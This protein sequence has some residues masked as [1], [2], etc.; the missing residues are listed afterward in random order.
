MVGLDRTVDLDDRRWSRGVSKQTVAPLH[1][2]WTPT[3]V[4][5]MNVQTGESAKAVSLSELGAITRGQNQ[6]IVGVG[7]N[8]VFLK[9]LRLP[10]AAPDDLRSVL[11]I[12]LGQLFPVPPDQLS[13]DFIQTSNQ[14]VEGYLT[15]VAAMRSELLRDLR[16]ELKEVG[17][18]PVRILPI[19]LASGLVAARA[20]KQ[21]ALV[22]EGGAHGLALDVVEGGVTRFSRQAS[23]GS[24]ASVE[25]KRTLSAAKAGDLPTVSVGTV[26]I[27]GSI[28]AAEGALALLHEAPHFDFELM[29]ERVQAAKRRIANRL[30]LASAFV[31]IALAIV[32]TILLQRT[33]ASDVVTRS[34]GAW[35]RSL[36]VMESD[37]SAD[38]SE[39]ANVVGIQQTLNRAFDSAQP[40]SDISSVVDDKLPSGAWLTG[41]SLERGKTIDV[42]GT[43]KAPEAVT[44]FVNALGSSPR[45]RGVTLVFAN[46]SLVG[47]TPVVQFD[48]GAF[49]I[50][51]LPMP[52]PPKRST[53][54]SSTATTTSTNGEL[55]Y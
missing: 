13:F 39:A 36:V 34:Q 21:D 33:Q 6:A 40:I 11:A 45:L 14:N 4:R 37:E 43:A 9:A 2:E 26:D 38:A 35:A 12:Q 28:R 29:E 55:G 7:H 27:P 22:A 18:T 48:I 44:E 30:R 1:V 53:T 49:A 15:V 41:I 50:G 20:G 19:S 5:A 32:V 8:H 51:N 52:V 47:E 25:A 46:S 54:G 10:K 24:E 3:L 42:R 31:V 23:I 17:L 16:A